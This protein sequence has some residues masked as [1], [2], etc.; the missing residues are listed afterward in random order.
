[1]YVQVGISQAKFLA[2]TFIPFPPTAIKGKGGATT[3]IQIYK[4]P[5]TTGLDEIKNTGNK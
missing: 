5:V 2:L 3:D 1:M 4:M